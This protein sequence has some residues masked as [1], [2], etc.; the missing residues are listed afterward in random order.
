M[1]G[2]RPRSSYLQSCIL[3]VD[4]GGKPKWELTI[5]PANR[6]DGNGLTV[7]S[8]LAP[9]ERD[10]DHRAGR[11]SQHNASCIRLP[12]ANRNTSLL[13]SVRLFPVELDPRRLL[14][15]VRRLRIHGDHVAAN[16]CPPPCRNA[17]EARIPSCIAHHRRW[18]GRSCGDGVIEFAIDKQLRP[19]T[20]VYNIPAVLQKLAVNVFRNRRAGLCRINR[21]TDRGCLR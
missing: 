2:P 6:P 18:R 3:C 17:I 12:F 5:S 9:N 16:G 8:I 11:A 19:D 14:S 13:E 20:G 10:L 4:C 21:G 15:C 1:K 7:R